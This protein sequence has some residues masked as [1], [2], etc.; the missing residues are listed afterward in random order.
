[1]RTF[2]LLQVRDLL[3]GKVTFSGSQ[4]GTELGQLFLA[5]DFPQRADRRGHALA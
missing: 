1:M 5:A 3:E 2:H 4:F